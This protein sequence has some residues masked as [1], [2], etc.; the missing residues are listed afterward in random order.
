MQQAEKIKV[1]GISFVLGHEGERNVL[2]NNRFSKRMLISL[3][4]GDSSRESSILIP[5]SYSLHFLSCMFP[6]ISTIKVKL[7]HYAILEI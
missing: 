1:C 5:A 4:L 2:R 7:I 6:S 3:R